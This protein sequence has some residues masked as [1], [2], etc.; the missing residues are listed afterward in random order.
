MNLNLLRSL[1]AAAIISLSSCST[2]TVKL[3]LPPPLDVPTIQAEELACL[4]DDTYHQLV[5]RDILKTERIKTL[6]EIIRSTH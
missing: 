3:P 2:V 4:A 1:G 5:D 6:E